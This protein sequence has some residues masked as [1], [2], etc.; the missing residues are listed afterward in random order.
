VARD[1]YLSIYLND[2]LAAATAIRDIA[3]RSGR[4]NRGTELGDYLGEV[5]SELE[6][7]RETLAR[8]MGRLGVRRDPVKRAA[9]WAAE[10]TGRL[11]LNGHLLRYSPLSRV[12]ELEGLLAATD[13][14]MRTWQALEPMAGEDLSDLVELCDRRRRELARHHATAATLAFGRDTSSPTR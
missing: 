7:S 9:A 1:K 13:L 4:S 6:R 14:E 2:H 12:L 10:K 8:V 3:A 11:K 5:V